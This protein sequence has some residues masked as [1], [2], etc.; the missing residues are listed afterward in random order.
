MRRIAALI[1]PGFELLDLYGP[2]EMFGFLPAEFDLKLFAEGSDPVAS[3]QGLRAQPDATL[4]DAES[5]DVLFVPGGMGTRREVGNEALLDWIARSAARAECTL[6]VC[7]GA[8]LLAKAG[9]LDGRRATTNK[10]AFH[11]VAEQGPQVDWVRAARWVED[12]A[13]VTSS[14]VS[15]GMDM[16]L[17]VIARLHGEDAAKEVA[18]KAEYV[19]QRDRDHDPFAAVHGLV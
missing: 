9:V 5:F 11:W 6:S 4:G 1:F 18:T 2:M 8:A 12:G 7:T 17:G 3:S 13:F 14:G 19:W 10:A 15:A 16:A